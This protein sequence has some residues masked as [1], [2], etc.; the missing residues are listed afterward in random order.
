[1]P[2]ED[3]ALVGLQSIEEKGERMGLAAVAVQVGVQGAGGRVGGEGLKQERERVLRAGQE[4]SASLPRKDRPWGNREA[5]LSNLILPLIQRPAYRNVD[6][7]IRDTRLPKMRILRP[8]APITPRKW[9]RSSLL[10][11]MRSHGHDRRLSSH[12]WARAI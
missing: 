11:S 4:G 12:G 10:S 7:A 3:D 1:M 8:A 6:L 5:H 2:E 9:T